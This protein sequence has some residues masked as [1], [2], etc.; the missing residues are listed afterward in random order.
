MEKGM[1]LRIGI[2]NDL[3]YDGRC[4][5]LNRLYETVALLNQGQADRLVVM[6]D[7]VD[8][9]SE[10]NACRLLREVAALCDSF[11]GAVCYMPGN[12]DLDHLSKPLFFQALGHS[13]NQPVFDQ[14]ENGISLIGLDGNFSPDGSEY[15]HGNFSWKEAFIP[16]GQLAWLEERLAAARVPVVL[17]SH[18]RVDASDHYSVRN[19]D[20]VRDVI[21]CSGKVKAVFQA[22]R[23]ADDLQQIDGTTYYTLGAHLDDA[24]PAMVY[25]GAQSIR[26]D[27]DFQTLELS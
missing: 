26:I 20:A 19:H 14:E 8:A 10:K 22:H 12:H 9:D 3:H 23:H 16:D 15:D 7:L 17:F 6:G 4:E 2:I 11:R 24:G 18:Q 13:G 5:A 27:R 25:A 1:P 21:R